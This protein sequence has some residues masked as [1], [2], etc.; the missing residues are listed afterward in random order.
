[1]TKT[2]K[3]IEEKAAE[4]A[5]TAPQG[6]SLCA[7]NGF[8]KGYTECA[9]DMEAADPVEFHKWIVDNY[10]KQPHLESDYAYVSKL[11]YEHQ[12]SIHWTYRDVSDLLTLYR[13]SLKK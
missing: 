6:S 8:I 2:T 12:Y 3:Q 5:A 9:K 13:E 1:M 10:I 4:Y 11:D 7:L